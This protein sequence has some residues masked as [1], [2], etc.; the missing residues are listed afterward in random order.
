M[1]QFVMLM[2][3]QGKVRLSKFFGAVYSQKEKKRVIRET[4]SRYGSNIE[5]VRNTSFL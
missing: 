5:N 1:I 4:T 3:R 2:N